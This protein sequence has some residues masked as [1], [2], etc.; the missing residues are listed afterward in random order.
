MTAKKIF[1]LMVA[2]LLTLAAME[3]FIRIAQPKGAERVPAFIVDDVTGWARPANQ[4]GFVV[5]RVPG[6]FK[7]HF[8]TNSRG[9]RD[10]EYPLEKHGKLRILA[11]GDSVTEG[12]GVEESETYP[13]VLESKYLG[14][15]EVWNLGVVG[16]GTDQELQQLRRV[17]DSHQPDVVILQFY[18]NDLPDNTM[19]RAR[20]WPHYVKPHFSVQGIHLVLTNFQGL[21]QQKTESSRETRTWS[22]R[23]R[24]GANQLALYRLAKYVEKTVLDWFERRRPGQRPASQASANAFNT[25]SKSEMDCLVLE[26]FLVEK[27]SS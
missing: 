13:K 12:W 8:Q 15:V 10:R 9:M 7:T 4:H 3:I 2:A 23:L 27:A 18:F 5:H 19:E 21:A 16:Y 25:F 14:N 22:A 26:N 11:L 24:S 1:V 6:V 20:W 17:I